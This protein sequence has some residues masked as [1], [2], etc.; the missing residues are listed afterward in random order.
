MC[1]ISRSIILSPMRGQGLTYIAPT[2]KVANNSSNVILRTNNATI[3]K[4]PN[5]QSDSHKSLVV[6]RHQGLLT[7]EKNNMR[8]HTITQK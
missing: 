8:L 5:W 7:K 3:G 6:G 2:K 4:L 1:R